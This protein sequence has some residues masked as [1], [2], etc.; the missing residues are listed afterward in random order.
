MGADDSTILKGAIVTPEPRDILGK[1]P[2]EPGV[3]RGDSCFYCPELRE[4]VMET[5]TMLQGQA[6][7]LNGIEDKLDSAR[8]AATSASVAASAAAAA[9]ASAAAAAASHGK[10]LTNALLTMAERDRDYAVQLT[11]LRSDMKHNSAIISG[12]VA[13]IV[14]G[15]W[16]LF[17]R[18]FGKS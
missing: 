7:R 10:E 16:W 18:V 11:E 14:T 4:R 3:S 5:H 2:P 13:L 15:L 8:M 17:D 12:I 9:A 1:P 6:Q